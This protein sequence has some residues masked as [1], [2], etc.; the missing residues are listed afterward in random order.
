MVS[1]VVWSQAAWAALTINS[2]AVGG[3]A[4]YAVAPGGTVATATISATTDATTTWKST[5][6]AIGTSAPASYTCA[7]TTDYAAGGVTGSESFSVTAPLAAG[8]YNTYF[9][10]ASNP[11]CAGST[12]DGVLSGSVIVSPP[13][14]SKTASTSA[15][16]VGD[17]I[18]F[19]VRATNSLV[20]A[21]NG[22]VVT[23]TLPT[24]MTYSTSA[25]TLG[26]VSVSG[27]VVT[28]TI[29]AIPANS[30]ADLTL[31]VSL[32]Q[33][34][35]LVNTASSTGATSA[36]SSVVVLAQAATH[37]ALDEPVGT[38]TG[39]AGEVLDSG[40][41]GLTGKRLQSATT[42]T[43]T[44]SPS[45]TIA[46]QYSSVV[47][48]FCN[49]GS[50]DGNAVVDVA[51]N[52]LLQYTNKL[53]A[54]AWIY[55]T[56]KPNS[57]NLYSILSND[58]NYE[59]HLDP[60]RKLYWWWG[61]SSLTSATSIPLNAWTHVAI[62]MD[63][64]A[65]GGR[66]RIYING[67]LDANTNNWIGTLSTNTCDFYI[68]GDV[69]TGAACSLISSR[70]FHGMI[71]EVKLYTYE[72]SAAEVQ[73]DM[74]LGRNCSGAF[75]HIEIDH[76]GSASVCTAETVTLKAC[77]D[78]ACTTLYPGSVTVNLSPSGWVGGNTFTFSGGIA[79]RQ[80]SVG[81]ASTV[82]LGTTSISPTPSN[83]TQCYNGSTQTCSMTFNA[84]S[85]N[86]DAVET[87]ASPATRI[88][89]KLANVNFNLDV[90]ALSS[91]TTINTGYTGTAVVDLVDASASTCPTGSGLNTAQ[92]VTFAAADK[93][94]KSVAFSYANAARNV[95]VR[96][97]VGSATP[98]C[99]SDNFAIRPQ[100]FSVSSSMTNT[101]LTGTPKATAGSAFTL[102]AAA[103]VSSGYDGTPALDSTKVNDHN[104]S[105]IAS[106]T[107]SGTFSAGTGA[108]ATGSAFKYLDVGNIQ[109]TTDAVTDTGFTSV[110]QTTDCIS[111]ST[112]NTLSGG[113]YGCNIGS[114]ASSKFGRWYPSHYSFSGALTPGCSAGSFTYMDQDALGVALTL[115]AH[116]TT[117]AAASASDPVVSRYTTGYPNLAPVTL[118]GSNSGSAVAIT[119]LASPTFPTMPNTA[120]WSA[121][122]F[123]ISDTYAFSKLSS[124][125]G[126][127]D[128]FLL[129]AT[130]ADPDGSA[131]LTSPGVTNTTK[132]RY[133]RL[134]IGNAYGSEFLDL[135]IPLEAQYWTSAGYVTNRADTC[136]SI[137]PS[138]I[139]FS[140]FTRNLSACETQLSPTS[141]QTLANG[142]ASLKL[143]KPGA[144]NQGSVQLTLNTGSTASGSTCLSS[145]SSA[146]TAGNMTWFGS[147][148]SGTETFGV[149]RAPYIY[150]RE[151]Y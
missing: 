134:K 129:Q 77:L 117:G 140:N 121:G 71:D 2:M 34:G 90:L 47:G 100:Q 78:S 72:L 18:T 105:A 94:R 24:G 48:S 26:T 113:K 89:T 120:L 145:S 107:L 5:G 102:T 17:V 46:S 60:N 95:R 92:S 147:N 68:G 37:F 85:C 143:T 32:T 148:P 35:T 101:A 1:L 111:G 125:D 27:Q 98:A 104:G 142:K 69:A 82:T 31:A 136:T 73:A 62:T 45:P 128:L 70:N 151:H 58:V 57:G 49:A 138:T 59:F 135:P 112:S 97:K 41:T 119:R 83:A 144:N 55:P 9:R 118:A 10:V 43:N 99:S 84:A 141:A 123:A 132:I 6:W 67:V 12:T 29:P 66:E 63:S 40:G 110:D 61:A 33:Q 81:S 93:G 106:G 19:R 91:S 108:S 146:A 65:T 25:A 54:T 51:S 38:W 103:G 109:L 79:T 124:P 139:M 42:T 126:P 3:A 53:S 22:V 52:T 39:T 130:L 150:L 4:S 96:M 23:D 15:A 8:T 80:L 76:D 13:T 122:I 50:F 44:V 30:Y 133:G 7:D 114:A 127:Y 21:L 14:L 36:T 149:F 74:T 115:K 28:W 11:S 87:S 75:D 20:L 137:T 131:L 86:F 64:S 116:A 16:V 88:Y 56:A